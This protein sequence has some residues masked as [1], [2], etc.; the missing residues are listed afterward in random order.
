MMFNYRE[1]VA[2]DDL[3]RIGME[4]L[5]ASVAERCRRGWRL[6][7][8]FGVPLKEGVETVCVLADASARLLD[9]LRGKPARRYASMTPQCPQAHL[10]ERELFE[11]WGIE[12][13]G[14]PWL[15]PVRYCPSA[16]KER[17]RRPG[18]AQTDY[19]RV[20]GEEVHEVAV[21]PVHA[22]VIEPG[23]FRFQCYGENVMHL[24][25]QLGFQ[26]RDVEKLMTSSP[27]SRALALAENISGDTAVGHA[28]AFCTVQERLCGVK[29]TDR[30]HVLRRLALELERLANHTRDLGA[31]GGD[32]GFLPTSAWNG[33]ITGD[34][35]N[36]TSELCGSRF[37][38]NLLCPGGMKWDVD[39]A[40]AESLVKRL[41]AA[42]RDARGSVDV[43]LETSSVLAR[44]TGTGKVSFEDARAVGL[45]GMAA[46]ACGVSMDA[47]MD[48]P[49][50]DLDNG[51][52]H[53][54]LRT[55]GDVLARTLIRSD[56]LNDS[57]ASAEADLTLLGVSSGEERCRVGM[58]DAL[59]AGRLAVA[60]V[61]G[62]RGEIC[63]VGITGP[64]G[65][66][67]AYKVVDPSFHNWTGLSLALRGEQ[68]SDFPLCNKSFNLSY[69][70]HDL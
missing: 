13:V 6:L 16:G 38:R 53:K 39:E 57:A 24:E 19:F 29:I 21:G 48:W 65:D 40:L 25:I 4:E 20:E 10:F 64:S 22:G 23:H 35:L 37:G 8:L 56:E 61:E 62:W 47:R 12:P 54:R 18:P 50:C 63:H 43:M 17:S 68:I 34:F 31:I 1:S 26:H 14:H 30:A 44:L 41:R 11:M 70:G 9:V 42:F 32:T 66:W 3:P 45:V 28:T 27:A 33:R 58:P 46:R 15:K 59:P 52:L 67:L 2:W 36:I 51:A 69:C 7:A 49:L 55:T 5:S 60:Q